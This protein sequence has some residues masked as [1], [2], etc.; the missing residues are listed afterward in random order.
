M[1]EVKGGSAIII[2]VGAE[3]G[4][5]AAVARRFAAGG[6]HAV[7]A[8]RTEDRLAERAGEIEAA[9]G[10]ASIHV[11][12]VRKENEVA[13]LFDAV[14]AAH[15]PIRSVTFNPGPNVRHPLAET[16]TWLFEHLWRVSCFGGFLVSREATQRMAASGGGSLL[17]TGATGSLR[18]A[19]G[20]SAFA[21]AKAGLRMVAQSAA[22]E[23]G[24]KGVHVAHII[25]DGA[26]DGEKIRQG[27]AE[28]AE[29]LDA[30]DQQDNMLDPDAI[31]ETFWQ[32]HAQPRSA[33][34]HE[35]DLRPWTEKF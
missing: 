32:V 20:H 13:A 3:R 29:E 12:D 10:S 33:W 21:A 24:P 16:K 27:F 34:T 5:G 23:Y 19:N 7:L 14:E 8:G 30:M 1:A 26:I 4:T 22:R 2:G 18:G 28:S 25:V 31:A 6:L 17:F 35:L 15:A 11:L 9:G